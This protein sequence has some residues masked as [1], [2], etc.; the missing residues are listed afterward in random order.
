MK[1]SILKKTLSDTLTELKITKQ[2]EYQSI[3]RDI[4]SKS[5]LYKSLSAEEKEDLIEKAGYLALNIVSA[6]KCVLEKNLET[7][8]ADRALEYLQQI[9]HSNGTLET[10]LYATLVKEKLICDDQ[11]S[12]KLIRILNN[13]YETKKQGLSSFH[14]L[15]DNLDK[16]PYK[17]HYIQ[18]CINTTR[19]M[20]DQVLEISEQKLE[21]EKKKRRIAESNVD[22]LWVQRTASNPTRTNPKHVSFAK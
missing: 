16:K 18:F 7:N 8:N 21:E 4:L 6:I 14:A 22:E 10:T 3:F 11:I 9:R 1:R 12:P 15:P 2:Q 19:T 5:D 13:N 20:M 17:D